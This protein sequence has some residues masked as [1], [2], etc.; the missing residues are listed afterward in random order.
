MI[1]AIDTATRW[2]GLALHDGANVI[3][4]HGWRSTNRQSVELAPE[5]A[6]VLSRSGIQ[7]ESLKGIA[8]ALGPGSYTGL[9][10]GLGLAKGMAL[11]HQIPLVGVPTLDIVAAALSQMPGKLVVIAEAGRHR[12]TAGIYEWRSSQGWQAQDVPVNMTWDELLEQL[13]NPAVLTGEISPQAMKR[14]RAAGRGL[15]V[16]RSVDRVRRAG[17]LAEV[18]WQRLRKGN[19]DNAADLTPVYLREP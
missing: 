10:I 12:I 9:R 19:V 4:E 15:R 13:E 8:V 16:V 3:A 6:R 11:A 2:T 18:G 17:Y 1:L 7:A 5:I 14:I